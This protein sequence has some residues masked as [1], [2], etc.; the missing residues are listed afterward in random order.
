MIL[1]LF[2][3][4]AS[5]FYHHFVD[6]LNSKIQYANELKYKYKYIVLGSSHSKYGVSDSFNSILNLSSLSET[7]IYNHRVLEKL[8][9]KV[10]NQTV[11]IIDISIFSLISP[12][13][14]KWNS[15]YFSAFK[16]HDFVEVSKSE[17]F[18]NTLF[19]SFY[20][21]QVL[22]RH[23]CS[24]PKSKS[25]YKKY[26][27]GYPRDLNLD[28]QIE[29]AECAAKRHLGNLN[30]EERKDRY[31]ETRKILVSLLSDVKEHNATPVLITTPVTY[32]YNSSISEADYKER[33]YDNI[34]SV[35]GQ[36][37][38]KFEYLDYSHDVRFE[39]NL[40]LFF[41]GDHLN[42]KGAEKFTEILLNDI[43]DLS[44]K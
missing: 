24:I 23:I 35:R 27:L 20:K 21:R 18:L 37:D 2:V 39:N 40:E 5:L 28:R 22:L 38:F 15:T 44:I 33:I 36:L 30:Y 41:D 8:N 4:C 42:C 1:Y 17:Y 6:P 16:L 32:F 43:S 34:E 3:F 13:N 25:L 9:S 7:I 29:E 14:K 26:I 31:I 10:S 11:V 12:Q 19:C